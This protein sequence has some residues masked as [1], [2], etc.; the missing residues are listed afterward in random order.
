MLSERRMLE[1]PEGISKVVEPFD[2]SLSTVALSKDPAVR[3]AGIRLRHHKHQ[4]ISVPRKRIQLRI[5][6][7]RQIAN[8]IA[9]RTD[10]RVR[11]LFHNGPDSLPQPVG[12][13]LSYISDLFSE[14]RRVF[15]GSAGRWPAVRGSLPRTPVKCS[16]RSCALR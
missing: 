1:K 8:Q 7:R 12:H 5:K 6:W 15:L 2:R 4:D 13:L 3:K 11:F 14:H 9:W 16:G 10:D